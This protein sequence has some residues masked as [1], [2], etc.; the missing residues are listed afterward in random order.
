MAKTRKPHSVM[1]A[2][3]AAV[4]VLLGGCSAY[5][6]R[7]TYQ[8]RPSEITLQTGD[9]TQAPPARV[10]GT[11]VGIRRATKHNGDQPSVEAAL[12][13]DNTSNENMTFD[14]STLALFSANAKRFPDPG[15]TGQ[16]PIQIQP[17]QAVRFTAEFPFPGN[18]YPGPF[19]L[20][21]LNLR[22]AVEFGGQ[23]H[24]QSATFTRQ[25]Q[26]EYAFHYFD[27]HYGGY[28]HHYAGH[29]YYRHHY[30]H[31]RHYGYGYGHH[32]GY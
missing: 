27:F 7:Y 23:L 2:M 25:P 5:D 29:H 16:I 15:L 11:I 31:H 32:W 19:D 1:P 18:D 22:W 10:L 12:L 14:P 17:G 28:G 3:L 8:P 13:F 9:N 6:A 21:G 26:N 20:D 30:P 4:L 24:Q